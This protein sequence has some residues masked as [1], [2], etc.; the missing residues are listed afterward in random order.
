MNNLFPS[1]NI[2]RSFKYFDSFFYFNFVTL[3]YNNGLRMK[4]DLHKREKKY[5]MIGC[6]MSVTINSN[7]WV[8]R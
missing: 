7:Q 5:E 2:H 3:S 6:L 1:K 8:S 4:P